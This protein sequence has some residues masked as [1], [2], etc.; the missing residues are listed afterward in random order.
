MPVLPTRLTSLIQRLCVATCAGRDSSLR[1]NAIKIT[2]YA[3]NKWYR[4]LFRNK[5]R[6]LR[7]PILRDDPKNFE[8]GRRVGF[9]SLVCQWNS[10][11]VKNSSSLRNEFSV[12]YELLVNIFNLAH[13]ISPDLRFCHACF[14]GLKLALRALVDPPVRPRVTHVAIPE[15]E[16]GIGL[17]HLE[18]VFALAWLGHFDNAELRLAL[19]STG[20]VGKEDTLFVF[21]YLMC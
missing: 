19:S 14:A 3:K 11:K 17:D 20:E 7:G 12:H 16:S 8:G 5:N 2:Q 6:C 15:D 18:G 1:C 4:L 9:V 13:R 21:G 10:P